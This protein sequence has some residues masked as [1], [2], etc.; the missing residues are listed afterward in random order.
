M[1]KERNSSEKIKTDAK[2]FRKPDQPRESIPAQLELHGMKKDGNES[3]IPNLH[4][5]LLSLL[6]FQPKRAGKP[7]LEDTIEG[8]RIYIRSNAL[9]PPLN[10]DP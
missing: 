9:P 8:A 5:D 6:L 10:T 2:M 3:A 1:L 7:C 4:V